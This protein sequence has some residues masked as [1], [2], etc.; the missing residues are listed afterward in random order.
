MTMESNTQTLINFKTQMICNSMSVQNC[1]LSK[2]DCQ[3]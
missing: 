2:K 3:C 1:T